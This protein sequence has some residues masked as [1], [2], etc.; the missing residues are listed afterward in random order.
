MAARK[1][2]KTVKKKI[3]KKAGEQQGLI[4][5]FLHIYKNGRINWQGQIIRLDGDKVL[6]QMFE[7]LMGEPSNVQAYDRDYIY[8]DNCKLYV[9]IDVWKAAYTQQCKTGTD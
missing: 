5:L 1:V 9:D 3:P 8:S 4:G 6:V 7:W 2:S